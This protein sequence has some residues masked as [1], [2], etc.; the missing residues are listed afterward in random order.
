M[1][2]SYRIHASVHLCSFLLIFYAHHV[3]SQSTNDTIRQ[4]QIIRDGQTI[5]SAGHNFVLGFFSPAN[6]SSRYAGVWY[7]RVTVQTVI[8]IANRRN[9][10]SGNSGVLRIGNDGSL[11][12]SDGNNI[13]WSTNT[14]AAST[15]LTAILLDTGNLILSRSEDVGD[16]SRAFWQSFNNPSDT[17][18][19]EMRA[20]M[21]VQTGEARIFSSWRSVGDPSPG[22]YSM[23][24]D[25]RGSPQIVIWEESHRRWRSGHWNGLVFTGVPSMRALY[26]YGY[27]LTDEG[28]GSMY[29][30][31][32]TVNSSASLRFMLRWDGIVE[33]LM[34]DEGQEVWNVLLSQPSSEC[35]V[36]NKC[37]NFGLCN[38]M[39]SPI[40]SCIEGFE[41]RYGD[42]W[43]KGN[44]SGGCVRRTALHC[45]RN[46]TDDGFMEVIRVKLPDF[47]DTIVAENTSRGCEGVCL[48]NCS[49][50]AYAFVS[51]I[52]CMTWSG[53]LVDIEQFEEGGKTVYARLAESELGN[54]RKLSRLA[55]I[56]I[57]VVGTILLGFAMLTV[58]RFRGK[59]KDS[60]RRKENLLISDMS[61]SRELSTDCSG[62][63]ELAIEGKDGNAPQVPLFSFNV[64]A[65]STNYFE[66]KNKLGQ[67]GF[68]PVYKG[69][70]PGGEEIAVKRL[71][72]WSGQGLEELKNELVL[73]AKLQHR[74]LVRLLGY[75]I[76]GEEKSLIY[77]YMPNKSLDS[78]LFDEAKKS[79]LDWSKR[80]IIIEGIARGL[81]YLHRDSRLRII[82]RDLKASNI[83]LDEDMNPKISDFGMARIFGGNQKEANTN[84]VVG[85]YGYM[86][87]EYAMEGLFSVKSDVYSFGVLLLEIVSGQRNTSFRSPECSNLIRHAWNLWSEG[88]AMELIDPSMA[89][90]CLPKEVIQCI[91]VGML[92]VQ[93]SAV[94]RP[95]VSSVLLMLESE[96]ASLPIPRQPDIT[97]MNS[98][99]M[100]SI[101]QGNEN[102][103]STDVTVTQVD[104]R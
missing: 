32:S 34:W 20:H 24:L 28:N 13:V 55:I 12:V 42:Q 75:C 22:N 58:W 46:G 80:F 21:N 77:E 29:F 90:S 15:N 103:S 95:T 6:S 79:E 31:Y 69:T 59:L 44:W 52:G 87:P 57:T 93:V 64:I 84:R 83:L 14:S 38:M 33:Q 82:H 66:N 27:R 35:E 61:R 71:S 60:W 11:L 16:T 3:F 104:G 17:F 41:P 99:D 56:V 19:P 30:T 73:I 37:G 74:N 9:P 68:G 45:D 70:L 26:S 4:G 18:L 98:S 88:R 53:D 1:G 101:M 65:V 92:C 48:R 39:H 63:N 25:P 94:H 86:S 49:C 62:Q 81:L 36:Y 97:S 85:T 40:C 8:W 89:S 78:F 43:S 76:E 72:K 96:N 50:N 2:S 47:A 102:V 91:H 54:K 23:G 67:G 10:I 5:I 7:Y 100:E 51:G